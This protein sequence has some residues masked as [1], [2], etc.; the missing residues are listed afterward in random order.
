V[1]NW[2]LCHH[3]ES[4]FVKQVLAARAEPSRRHALRGVRYA[5]HS[6]GGE[7]QRREIRDVA[8]YRRVLEG[9][10]QI[11]LPD[12]PNLDENLAR[13]IAENENRGQPP[14]S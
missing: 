7:T 2:Y 6:A 10:F 4:Q 1:S 9:P 13:M 5:I 3:P 12:A 11:R 14:I 8:E